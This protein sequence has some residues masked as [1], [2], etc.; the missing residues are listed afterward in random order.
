MANHYHILVQHILLSMHLQHHQY[1]DL[2][3]KLIQMLQQREQMANYLI[4]HYHISTFYT[5]HMFCYIQNLFGYSYLFFD[6]LLITN[7]LLYTVD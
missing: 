6:H 5:L 1:Y 4:S 2:Y 7:R 3:K